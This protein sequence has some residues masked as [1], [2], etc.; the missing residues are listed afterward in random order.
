METHQERMARLD[1]QLKQGDIL[2]HQLRMANLEYA[3][4]E[5]EKQARRLIVAT[6]GK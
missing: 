6:E 5:R 3:V 1:K 2:I 4:Q